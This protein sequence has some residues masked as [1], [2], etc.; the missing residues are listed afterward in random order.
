MADYLVTDTELTSIADALRSVTGSSNSI[1]FPNGMATTISGCNK[2][3]E[4]TKVTITL[5]DFIS[6]GFSKLCARVDASLEFYRY[7]TFEIIY[8]GEND[9]EISIGTP[10]AFLTKDERWM[11]TFIDKSGI[12]L[13]VIPSSKPSDYA[14]YMSKDPIS[15]QAFRLMDSKD[16][17][18]RSFEVQTIVDA[19]VA[20]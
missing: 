14:V 16:F 3:Y 7:G 12:W 19:R 17:P 18:F 10:I 15:P 5:S 1:S 6:T 11:F 2:L 13:L 4:S 20:D 8:S 9:G